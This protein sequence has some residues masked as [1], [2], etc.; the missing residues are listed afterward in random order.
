MLIDQRSPRGGVAAA[1]QQL[2]AAAAIPS[3]EPRK[4]L[5][6]RQ[7][8]GCQETVDDLREVRGFGE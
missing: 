2:Q 3:V 1:P 4:T 6:S 5:A 7:L 8:R